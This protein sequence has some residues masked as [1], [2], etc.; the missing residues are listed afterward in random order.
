DAVFSALLSVAAGSNKI[1]ATATRAGAEY[2]VTITFPDNPSTDLTQTAVTAAAN[3]PTYYIGRWVAD[4]G[5]SGLQPTVAL[6]TALTP[7]TLTY[8]VTHGAGATYSGTMTVE[9]VDG[10]EIAV[11]WTASA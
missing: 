9:N 10:T 2:T 5:A 7:A 3:A 8:T 4:A 1:V 11:S 6:P